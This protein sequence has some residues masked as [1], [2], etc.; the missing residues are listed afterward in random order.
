LAGKKTAYS[1]RG[2]VLPH[3]LPPCFFDLGGSRHGSERG[4]ARRGKIPTNA[5]GKPSIDNVSSTQQEDTTK[6]TTTVGITAQSPCVQALTEDQ[7]T[8]EPLFE[9]TLSEETTLEDVTKE[10]EAESVHP[11]SRF[12]AQLFATLF[13]QGVKPICA[14]CAAKRPEPSIVDQIRPGDLVK[15]AHKTSDG[16][17]RLAVRVTRIK[18]NRYRGLM[19]SV[20][21]LDPTLSPGDGYSFNRKD[22]VEVMTGL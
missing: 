13:D 17:E 3:A 8:D 9:Q 7:G 20:P 1:G 5:R 2:N 4:G 21:V 16:T 11:L 15:V 18:G 19:Y 14:C 22:I 10:D 12:H 6:G